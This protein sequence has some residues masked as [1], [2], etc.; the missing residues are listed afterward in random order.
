MKPT[1]CKQFLHKRQG[2]SGSHCVI[3][4]LKASSDLLLFISLGTKD[5]ILGANK[6]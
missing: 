1:Y 6:L 3:L 2:L 5:H 4:N